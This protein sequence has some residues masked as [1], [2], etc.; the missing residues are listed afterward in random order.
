[1]K[2]FWKRICIF[3][4]ISLCFIT[5]NISAAQITNTKTNLNYL[6][7]LSDS[8]DVILKS[9]W[10]GLKE[11]DTRLHIGVLGYTSIE[12][13]IFPSKGTYY[14]KLSLELQ[15]Y[16]KGKWIT[17]WK[18]TKSKKGVNGCY[19]NRFLYKGYKYRIKN[20]VSVYKSKGG[21]LLN[22]RTFYSSTKKY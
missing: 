17:N 22:S 21:K 19:T 3:T 7:P 4:L 9:S 14:S 1:M 8:T 10:T 5:T 15:Q 16:K 20:N 12:S 13:C 2:L 6:S 18:F 11:F